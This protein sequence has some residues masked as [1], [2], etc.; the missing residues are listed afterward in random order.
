MPQALTSSWIALLLRVRSA[1]ICAAFEVPFDPG[2]TSYS[3][4]AGSTPWRLPISKL[5]PW[6]AP[7]GA[8]REAMSRFSEGS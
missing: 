1:W 8:L 5:K 6:S 4:E 7:R 3:F 2:L